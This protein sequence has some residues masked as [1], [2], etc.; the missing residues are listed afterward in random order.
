MKLLDW[1]RKFESTASASFVP[2]E[3]DVPPG[4]EALELRFRYDPFGSTDRQVNEEA[5]LAAAETYLSSSGFEGQT[6]PG[7]LARLQGLE[8]W[9]KLIYNLFNVTLYDPRGRFVGRWDTRRK[10]D[11]PPVFISEGFSSG[12]FQRVRPAPGRW[13]ATVEVWNVFTPESTA[14][15]EVL[16]HNQ[17]PKRQRRAC[18]APERPSPRQR[19][20]SPPRPLVPGVL[21]GEMHAHSQHSDG[22]FTVAELAERAEGLGLDFVALTDHNTTSGHGELTA[23]FPVTFLRGEELTTFHGHFC[24]YGNRKC[25]EWHDPAGALRIAGALADARE[26]GSL[27]S[28]AHPYA[29]PAPVC[30]GCRF[31]EGSVPLQTFHLMEIWSGPWCRKFPAIARAQRLW[32]SLWDQGLN[33][34][35][36]AARDWHGKGEEDTPRTR[37]PVTAVLAATNDEKSILDAVAHGRVFAT[38]GPAVLLEAAAG[39]DQ[40]D[41]TVLREELTRAEIRLVHNGVTTTAVALPGREEATLQFPTPAP[42]RYRAEL[43]SDDGQLLTITNHILHTQASPKAPSVSEG[44]RGKDRPEKT[45]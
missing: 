17:H 34:V 7:E 23:E 15:L 21:Y 37:F 9:K 35:G 1:S 28:L 33:P 14:H 5:I 31:A 29:M 18:S 2:V 8:G 42:G 45:R 43:W 41:V 13:L 20:Y 30:V 40:L 11:P 6:S 27:V 36:I 22:K 44:A 26:A 4:V 10:D 19:P 3:F 39:S 16:G 38:S 25:Y 32:D 12:G 24:I